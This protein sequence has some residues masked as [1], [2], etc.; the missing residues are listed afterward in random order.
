M[1]RPGARIVAAFFHRERGLAAPPFTGNA[2]RPRRPLLSGLAAGE[3]A[4][5]IQ[6][7]DVAGVLLEQVKQ[8]PFQ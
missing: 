1:I 5:D 8:D 2:D 3:L 6:V 7:A 4:D